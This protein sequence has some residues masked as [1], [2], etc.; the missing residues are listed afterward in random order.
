MTLRCKELVELITN[1]LE[2]A[3]SPEDHTRFEAHLAA[4]T[5]CQNYV[6]QMQQ[7]IRLVG[8]LHEE[9][10]SDEAQTALLSAFRQWKQDES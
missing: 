10:I 8:K 7:T 2:G 9:A 5:G 1:Y 3:L 6:D 4:C